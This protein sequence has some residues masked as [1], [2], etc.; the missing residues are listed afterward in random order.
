M[1]LC[2]C[3][4]PIGIILHGAKYSVRA[5]KKVRKNVLNREVSRIDS[6]HINHLI[7]IYHVILILNG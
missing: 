1:Q 5:K 7:L 3:N 2:E 6:H 4:A